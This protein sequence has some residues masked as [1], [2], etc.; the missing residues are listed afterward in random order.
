MMAAIGVREEEQGWKV[1]EGVYTVCTKCYVRFQIWECQVTRGR[2]GVCK[3]TGWHACAVYIYYLCIAYQVF[4]CD[5][6]PL[7]Q[8]QGADIFIAITGCIV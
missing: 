4:N 3:C 6:S 2:G 1:G 8:E 7:L 5:V